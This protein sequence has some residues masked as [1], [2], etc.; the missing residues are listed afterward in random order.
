MMFG[1]TV[2]TGCT[3]CNSSMT[4][5]V[6]TDSDPNENSWA[7]LDLNNIVVQTGPAVPYPANSTIT[8]SICVPV[9]CYRFMMLDNGNNGI[10]GGGYILR[11]QVGTQRR[12][13]DSWDNGAFG[14]TS[15]IGNNLGFCLPISGNGLI[16]AHRDKEDWL[17]NDVIIASARPDVSAQWG[18]GDQTDDGYQFWFFDP[19]G[20]FSRRIF[21]SHALSGGLGP[22]NAVRA[23]K[24]A[25][26]SMV[27]PS[28][29]FNTLLNARVRS[30]VNGVN[31]EWGEASR[32][33]LLAAPPACPTTRLNNTVGDIH[34]S[35]G[36]A[37]S[38]GGSERIHCFPV[39]GANLYQF[40]FVQAGNAYARTITSTTASRLLNWVTVQPLC[41]MFTYN[42]RV[43]ASMDNGVTYCPYGAVCQVTISNTE[44]GCTPVGPMVE[45][46]HRMLV[47]NAADHLSLALFPNPNNG[48]QLN[49]RL[50]EPVD[51]DK[52]LFFVIFDMFGKRVLQGQLPIASGEVNSIIELNGALSTGLYVVNVTSGDRT[53]QQRLVIE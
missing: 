47:E 5:E 53:M 39:A 25:L 33:R 21:R 15:S 6:R 22:A 45:G 29:P 27:A 35:C 3:P 24:L 23:T 13:I 40:E 8:E 48:H 44:V 42:V 4:L 11:E 38:F 43:R 51:G 26:S 1:Q 19:H 14:N 17:A 7:I 9:G 16:A 28:L 46:D 41:G 34:Y 37:R 52:I 20:L 12:I 49:V 50:D 32:F 36:V 10:V 2:I 18:M 30:R 31:S